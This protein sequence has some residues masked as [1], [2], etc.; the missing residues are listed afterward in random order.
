MDV[1]SGAPDLQRMRVDLVKYP[2]KVVM[3]PFGNLGV[4]HRDSVLGTENQMNIQL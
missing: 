3:K 4:K 2:G 1:V